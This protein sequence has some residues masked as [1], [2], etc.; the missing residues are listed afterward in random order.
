MC[1]CTHQQ[2]RFNTSHYARTAA[3]I[4]TQQVLDNLAKFASNPNAMPHF[5]YSTA[6]QSQ[7]TDTLS[8]GGNASFSPRALTSWSI[9]PF[10][11]VRANLESLTV[12]TVTDPRKLELMRCAYQRVVCGHCLCE[13]TGGCPDCERRFND[14]YL[15]TTNPGKTPALTEDGSPIYV[16][17]RKSDQSIEHYVFKTKNDFNED[18][19]RYLSDGLEVPGSTITTA[20]DAKLIKQVFTDDSVA[21][22]SKRTGKVTVECLQSCW[23]K[24]GRKCDIPRRSECALIGRYCDTYIWVP[25]SSRDELTKLTFVILDIAMNNPATLPSAATKEVVTLYNKDGDVAATLEE[26]VVK[27]TQQMRKDDKLPVPAKTKSSAEMVQQILGLHPT[28]AEYLNNMNKSSAPL[29]QQLEC[30][31]AEGS[32]VDSELRAEISQ[33][34]AHPVPETQPIDPVNR[35]SVNPAFDVLNSNLMLRSLTPQQ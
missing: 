6:G 5:T 8:G 21:A 32:P 31:A 15:G 2:L 33:H 27:V 1:G 11:G 13:R 35:P 17:L 30:L 18:L 16:L 26:G 12:T 7:V 14:F 20:S 24:V 10:S 29:R 9:N 34:L 28:A 19:Y 25:A 22:L 23:F 3:D 4:N